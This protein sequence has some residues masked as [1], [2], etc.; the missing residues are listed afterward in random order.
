MRRQRSYLLSFSHIII[1]KRQKFIASV[2]ILSVLLFLSEQLFGKSDFYIT[3][4]LSL[5]A[6]FL[7]IFCEF[8]DIRRNYP[9]YLFT[10]PLFLFTLSIGLFYFLIPAR[11]LTRLLITIFYAIGLY[12]LF[13]S[14]NIFIVASLRTIP[15]L[16]GARIVSFVTTFVSYLLLDI[17]VFTLHLSLPLTALFIFLYSFLAVLQSIAISYE[18]SLKRTILWVLALSLALVEIA[19]ILWFWP[20]SP[21]MIAIFLAVFFNTI[22]GL[23]RTWLEKRLF[24]G[25]LWEYIWM[26][27]VVLFILLAFSSWR[28]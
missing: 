7:F 25:A 21:T 15:L 14:Q 17:V 16:S 24:K 11:I 26:T 2:G 19:V 6:A 22:V 23:S 27:V 5:F 10:I 20:A 28:G 1:T 3:I 18:K 12:S 4:L 9:L 8:P 13:L